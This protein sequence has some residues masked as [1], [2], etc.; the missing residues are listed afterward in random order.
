MIHTYFRHQRATLLAFDAI[1]MSYSIAEKAYSNTKGYFQATI[2]F[3]DN[4][5][6]ELAEVIDT[7]KDTITKYRYHYMDKDNAL[8]FRYDNAPHYPFLPTFPHHKHTP[9]QVLPSSPPTLQSILQ[10]ASKYISNSLS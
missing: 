2:I 8:I 6:I 5:R 4:S 7:H 1:I 3:Q 9:S 10:E